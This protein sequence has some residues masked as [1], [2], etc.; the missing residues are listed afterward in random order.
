MGDYTYLKLAYDEMV[1]GT[2]NATL[3]SFDG[4]EFWIPNSLIG[5]IDDTKGESG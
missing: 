1:H 4:D 2:D 5:D 3:L